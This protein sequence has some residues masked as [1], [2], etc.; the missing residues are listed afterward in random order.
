MPATEITADALSASGRTSEKMSLPTL[1]SKMKCD[2]EG[3]E[4]ELTLVYNQFKSSVQL[5]QQQAAL[6]FTS[7]VSGGVGS[8]PTVAKD[9]GDRAMFLAHVT[10]FYP[11][12]LLNYPKELVEFLSSSARV[13]P[14]SLRVTVTQAL[15]LLLNRKIVAIKE[16]LPLFMELQVLSDKPLKVLAFSH[17]IH[18]I[19]RMNQ[20]HKNETENRAL[21]SI[22]FSMLQEEDEKKAMR[23]LVTICDLHRRKVWFDDRAANAICRACFHM[24]SRVMIAA[25]SFLLDYEKIEQENDSDESSDEEEP[26]HQ[27]HVVV[28]K[29]AIYKANNTGTTSSKKK[30]KA[31]LQRVIRSMKKQQRMSSE[32]ENNVNYYS[33]LTS[34]KDPQGFAEKLFSKL[35][36]CKERFE[37]KMMIVKV[38]A[39]TVGL[40]R[41]ILLNF[42]PFLQKYVQPHQR[43]VTNL[44]AAAVQACHDMVPPDAVE[45]LFKQIVNQFVHDR[46]R[47]ESIAVGLN[48]V[49][50][51]CLRIPLLM[52]EDLLQ[53]LVLYKKSHEK[54]VSSAA[55]SLISLFREVCPSLLVKKDRGRPIDPKAKPKAFGE[56]TIPSDVPGVDLLQDDVGDDVSSSSD[57]DDHLND[58]LGEEDAD[59]DDDVSTREGGSELNSEI[60]D[61][62]DDGDTLMG[63]EEDEMREDESD[64]SCSDDDNDG[65]KSLGENKGQKRKFADFD[66]QLDSASQSLRALKRLAGAKSENN[67]TSDAV[68]GILSNEDFQRI[69]ELKAKKEAK[70]ALAQHGMLKKGSDPKS[71]HFKIPS[72]DQLSLKRVDGY[73]LEANIRKKMTKEERKALMKAGREETGKYQS[74]AAVKQKKTGGLSNRQKEHKKAMPLVAKRSKIAR[75]KREK[76]MKQ[77]GADKQF[78]GRKAWK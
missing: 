44:L 53:D 7:A 52:T 4:T 76:K 22:L 61:D 55:R 46:S 51:I 42:Y 31:K 69:K 26:T 23:S 62:D 34:L 32:R 38:V 75:V 16:T 33:P 1:Q 57:M 50:E 3:Y 17:V 71:E 70:L 12:Q 58:D 40:H 41:L 60:E 45:P 56:V 63:S 8:D 37:I 14:S 77:R 19:R 59:S 27:P 28:S 49:R 21:Q 67:D 48:V 68:D 47:T 5:F 74:K 18:S 64:V 29:E 20:K 30:K 13:L 39:R 72:S 2:P 65:V 43:D 6:N 15:I 66:E 24:S 10:P 73:S 25:L 35:Q 78:R 54:A 9:L 36:T 11:V